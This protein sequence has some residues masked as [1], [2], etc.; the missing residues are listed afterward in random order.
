MPRFEGY[1]GGLKKL[2]AERRVHLRFLP[3]HLPDD[4]QASR[5]VMD[6]LG[7]IRGREAL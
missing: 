5:M 4:E 1:R 6:L 2:A 3:F 7:D